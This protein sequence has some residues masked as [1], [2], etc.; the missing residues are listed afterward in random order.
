M[1][2]NDFIWAL[3]GL[4]YILYALHGLEYNNQQQYQ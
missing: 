3:Y 2:K 4:W 1:K